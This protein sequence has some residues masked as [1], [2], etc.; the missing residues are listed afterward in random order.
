MSKFKLRKIVHGGFSL[1]EIIIAIS[2][3]LF[4][5][6]FLVTPLSSVVEKRKRLTNKY[7]RIT[8]SVNAMEMITASTFEGAAAYDGYLFLDGEG[9]VQ[10]TDFSATLK[11]IVVWVG[12][13]AAP[14]IKF[15]TLKVQE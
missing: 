10:V 13:E 12:T 2:L 15:E 14:E 9:Q 7:R 5:L 3:L 1:I 6:G 8:Q 4:V 11:K